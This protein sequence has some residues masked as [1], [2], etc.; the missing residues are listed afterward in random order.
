MKGAG[1]Q[2]HRG[3]N[4]IIRPTGFSAGGDYTFEFNGNLGSIVIGCV[5]E[6]NA[7]CRGKVNAVGNAVSNLS[8][9][10]SQLANPDIPASEIDA[11][12]LAN[13][14]NSI[15]Q[16]IL[17]ICKAMP[18]MASCKAN[19]PSLSKMRNNTDGSLQVHPT[20]Q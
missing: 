19:Y 11:Q 5:D 18:K 14:A 2:F 17:P 20:G 13:A 7:L 15:N 4:G 8:E 10:A 16:T 12:A 1:F 9:L 3:G 6:G